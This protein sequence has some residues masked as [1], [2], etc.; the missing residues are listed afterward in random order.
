MNSD[1]GPGISYFWGVE[2]V[3]EETIEGLESVVKLWSCLRSH[4]SNAWSDV[5]SK[6][7]S[8]NWKEAFFYFYFLIWEIKGK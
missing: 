4:N 8:K 5:R 7:C 3:L 1:L 6:L 2:V